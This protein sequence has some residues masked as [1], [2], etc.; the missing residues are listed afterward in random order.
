M[1]CLRRARSYLMLI[2]LLSFI[3]SIHAQDTTGLKRPAYKLN[4]AVDKDTYYEDDIKSTPY[5]LP[6]TSIQLYPGETIYVEVIEENGVIKKMTAVPVVKD[7]AKTITI[8]F[9]QDKKG[10]V[11]ELMMLKIENPFRYQLIYKAL[12]FPYQQKRWVKTDVLPVEPKLSAYET[13]PNIIISI[14]L[15]GWTFQHT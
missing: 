15:R 2:I 3:R 6:D 4:V 1:S 11:H 9:S 13:W 12:I 5:I 8:S 7:P 10:N 14:A